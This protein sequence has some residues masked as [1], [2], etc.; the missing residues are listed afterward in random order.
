MLYESISLL[1]VYPQEHWPSMDLCAE[2]LAASWP[3][4]CRV[5]LPGFRRVFSS[6]NRGIP[7]NLDRAWNRYVRYPLHVCRKAACAG[8]FHVVDHS[9]AHLSLVLPPERVGVYVHDLIPFEPI[10]NP[11]LP[12]PWWHIMVF[13]LVWNGLRRA[14]VLFCN[15]SALRDR[16]VMIGYWPADRIIL[17][18]LGVCEEFHPTGP[19]E[20]GNYLLHVGSCVARKRVN[21]LLRIFEEVRKHC[22]GL[23]LIQA[24]GT[25][26]P[27]QQA[28]L[29]SFGL[30][31]DVEQRRGL[32]RNELARLYR[33]ARVVLMPSDNEGFGLPVIEALACGAPVVASDLPTLR[34]AGGGA[35]R[36]VPVG[37]I[38]GF[39]QATLAA[40]E[41]HDPEAGLHHAAR[42]TWANHAAI[43]HDA[44]SRLASGE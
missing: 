44:Y 23:R 36:H 14:A 21:D 1:P 42:F 3:T 40:M 41:G 12:K 39:V 43:I 22:P 20:V 19:R 4:D 33:G 9:Y 28:F 10:L 11:S 8:F 30:V 35:A 5:M 38:H 37:D 2:R 18:P 24:G 7:W 34:E 29:K 15:S 16:L 25:F 13:G 6:R 32:T 27:E 26:S 31:G 17:A